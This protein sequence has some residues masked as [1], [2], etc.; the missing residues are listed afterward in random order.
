[1]VVLRPMSVSRA[2][3]RA[4]DPGRS[5][6]S[7]APR[8]IPLKPC[9]YVPPSLP[10]SLS[11]SSCD[12][13]STHAIISLLIK[14]GT[15]PSLPSFLPLSLPPSLPPLS[16]RPPT[17]ACLPLLA[18]A[19]P[20]VSSPWPRGSNSPSSPWLTRAARGH[21]SRYVPRKRGREGGREGVREGGWPTAQERQTANIFF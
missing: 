14:S 20:C 8:V 21:P 11:P 12:G 18:T 10:L 9:R 4:S 16:P 13:Q 1:M 6:S 7:A 3:S 17:T 15:H 5:L 19:R 2:A